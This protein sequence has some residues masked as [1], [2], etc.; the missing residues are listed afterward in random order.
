MDLIKEVND[1]S[2][3]IESSMLKAFVHEKIPI[4]EIG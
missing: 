4:C 2:V 3:I 1:H